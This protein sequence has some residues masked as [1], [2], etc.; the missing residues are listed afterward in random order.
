MHMVL[1][2]FVLLMSPV[3]VDSCYLF[4]H[5]LQGCCSDA[6]VIVWVPQYRHASEVTMQ[7]MGEIDQYQNTT[8][9]DS[10]DVLRAPFMTWFNPNMDN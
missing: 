1:S 9:C 2:Y 7:G 6:G 5:I 4:S 10:W 8:K 3:Y